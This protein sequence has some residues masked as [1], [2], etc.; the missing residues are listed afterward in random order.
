MRTKLILVGVLVGA[1]ILLTGC[2]SPEAHAAMQEDLE[3]A[4]ENLTQ[5]QSDYDTLKADH[6]RLKSEY[7]QYKKD[8]AAFLELTEA[9]QQA[10]IE[11]AKREKDIS[12]LEKVK[13]KLEQEVAK[14]E[15]KID[16]LNA[17][18]IKIAGK[19][20]TYPAG[21]FTAGKDFPVGRYKIY[22]GSSNFFVRSTSGRSRVN[23][24]LGGRY[25]VDEYIYTF[26][27]GEEVQAESSFKMVPVE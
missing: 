22:G 5:L 24:I 10:E 21:Y 8:S 13:S 14:L 25:G 7:N 17:D 3:A 20:K 15:S 2:I 18:V 4:R 6:D 26:S 16:E 19:A 23:I 11:L 1:L 12:D 27:E 9:E